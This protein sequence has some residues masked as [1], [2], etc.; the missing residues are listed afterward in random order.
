MA[1]VGAPRA[2]ARRAI[3]SAP[4]EAKL[5]APTRDIFGLQPVREALAA[6]GA[7][8]ARVLVVAADSRTNAG[9][10]SMAEARG[11]KVVRVDAGQLDRR[12]KQGRHQGVLA[13]VPP[14]RVL[15]YAQ[16]AAE[17]EGHEPRVI[18]AL[19]EIEDPQNFGA[20]VRT[21]VALGA[22]AVLWP[23][24][25]SAPLSP[26]MVRASAGAVEHARLVR[27]PQLAEALGALHDEHAFEIVGLD[28]NGD[29]ELGTRTYP[30]RIVL[31]VGAEGKGLRKGVK[32]ACNGLMRLPMAGPI[33]SLNASVAAALALYGVLSARR[34]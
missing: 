3:R 9:I 1:V 16:L 17:L 33:A 5:S 19:D 7:R 2:V 18:V 24:H 22:Y 21:A 10:V 11:V 28:A 32:R 6:Y 26:A 12:T 15:D 20:I 14:L 23:E 27:V 13:E 31:V 25:H 8:V 30:D 34:T 4:T 29:H